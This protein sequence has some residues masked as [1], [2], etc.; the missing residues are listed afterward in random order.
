MMVRCLDLRTPGQADPNTVGPE[1]SFTKLSRKF[2]GFPYV[3]FTRIKEN[4]F[5]KKQLRGA[6]ATVYLEPTQQQAALTGRPYADLGEC[7]AGLVN[8]AYRGIAEQVASH[9]LNPLEFALLRAFLDVEQ[10]TITQMA[11][12]LPVKTPR[13]SRLVTNLV[14]RGLIRRRRPPSDRRVVF[15]TLTDEG[16]ALTLELY[17]RVQRYEA[18]LLQGVSEDEKAVFADVTSK[19]VSNYAVLAQSKEG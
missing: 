18:K 10:W 1:K 11:Q 2:L 16:R 6:N 12:S 17:G 8:V 19:V 4:Y 14:D 5:S 3:S 15:L 13:I 7:V 9:D